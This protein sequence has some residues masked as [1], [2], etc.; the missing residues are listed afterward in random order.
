MIEK[1]QDILDEITDRRRRQRLHLGLSVVWCASL[2]IAMLLWKA[3]LPPRGWLGI[4][5]VAAL[6]ASAGV[7]LWS[8]RITVDPRRV[9]KDIEAQNPALRTALLAALDQKIDGEPTYL[10]QRVILE[11]LVSANRDGWLD[12][13]PEGRLRVFQVM[14]TVG[15]VMLLLALLFL[16]RS[17]LPKAATTTAPQEVAAT[18]VEEMEFSVEPGDIRIERGAPLTVQAHFMKGLPESVTLEITPESGGVVKLPMNRPFTDPVFHARIPAVDAPSSYK[19]TAGGKESAVFKVTLYDVPA[20]E[21]VDAVVHAPPH[22]N[23]PP[24]ELGD[25]RKING[26]EGGRLQLS[27]HANLPG[28]AVTLTAKDKPAVTL[29]ATAENPAVYAVDIPLRESVR[30]EMVLTDADG[31]RNGRKD[32]LDIRVT[33]NKAPVVKVVLPRKN[34]KATAI[35]EV[36]LEARIQD[37]SEIAAHG[38]RYT[39]DGKEWHEVPGAKVPGEKEP[40]VSHVVDLEAIGAK[41]KDIL[42]WNAWAEDIGPDGKVRH[43]SGDIHLVRVRDFDEEFYQQAAPPGAPPGQSPAADLVKI[44]TQILNGTWAVLRDHT[45]IT[46]SAPERSELET[47]VKSQEAAV[48][49]SRELEKELKE[50][51][52]RESVAN[53]RLAMLDAITELKEAYDKTSAEPLG[54]A[55]MHEQTALRHL[56]QL[57]SSKT[58]LMTGAQGAGESG[59]DD[60]PKEDLDLKKMENPY[61]AE[62]SAKPESGAEAR[63]AMEVLQRLAD[64]AKRQRDLNE[65]IKELQMALKEADTPE[66][67]AELERRLK[68][69]RDQQRELAEDMNRLQDKTEES[70][71]KTAAEQ[72]KKALDEAR[73]KASQ[74]EADLSEGKLGDALAAGRRTQDSL[75]KAEQDMRESGAAKLGEQLR[76]LRQEARALDKAQKELSAKSPQEGGEGEEAKPS[77]GPP[78][79]GGLQADAADPVQRQRDGLDKLMEGMRDAAENAEASQ[80]LVANDLAEALRHADQAGVEKALEEMQQSGGVDGSSAQSAAKAA[81]EGI[82]QLTTEVEKTAERILGNE[83]KALRYAREELE[84]LSNEMAQGKQPGEG[85]DGKEGD[86]K[87]PG[88][89]QEGK[90][91][92][93]KGEGEGKEPGGGEGKEMAGNEGKGGEGKEGQQPGE[94]E[95]QQGEGDQKGQAGKGGKDGEGQEGEQGQAGKGEG[96]GQEGQQ[97]EGQGQGQQPGGMA[98][99]DGEGEGKGGQPGEGDATAQADAPDGKGGGDGGGNNRREDRGGATRDGFGTSG[100]VIT[101]ESF[102]EWSD[103]LHDIGAVIEDPQARSAVA[104]A[105][106]TS[107]DLRRDFKRHSKEPG[108]AEVRAGVVEPLTEAVRALDARLR[109]LN[110]ENPL[111]PIGR[112]PVPDRYSEVVRRYF[113]ELGK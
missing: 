108:E 97:G 12:R 70:A 20:L 25:V 35:Q 82:S 14:Q 88:E 62:K 105:V 63:E 112:D 49:M 28:L 24:E 91:Q 103:R 42:M 77:E 1:L 53:A 75:E 11:A 67:K 59:S 100:G 113:E 60:K 15:L 87:A 110:K 36:R 65:E 85:Q 90:E 47:L 48:E 21:K 18:V 34:D 80:P 68:Q 26:V 4:L 38:L 45:E 78:R 19:V 54:D 98:G 43:V 58:I 76:E 2:V 13:L 27:L 46:V 7:W 52:L 39:L 66:E 74:A 93:G 55:I 109:E 92:A 86:G 64:L 95:G 107:R 89:S 73:E 6:C 41:P 56:H 69:L 44:Q 31:R 71:D 29:A 102:R 104:R 10:Q 32:M 40:L 106:K 8:R 23:L 101:S 50:P 83:A 37:D 94:G 17:H 61:Q 111:A 57:A 81:E 72:N 99:K 9:A 96:E 16:F 3:G 84:K 51:E 33:R 22:L 30:Y 79:L 5:S